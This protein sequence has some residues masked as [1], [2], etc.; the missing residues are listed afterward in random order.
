MSQR[1]HEAGRRHTHPLPLDNNAAE[2][3]LRALVLGKK[4]DLFVGSDGAGQ[5]LAGLA[6]LVDT[7]ANPEA[8]LADVLMRL[9][10][11]PAARLDE[12]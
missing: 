4:N 5:P 3:T 6:S 11:H 2:W 12:L 10:S 9:G 1:T 7:C 8:Y